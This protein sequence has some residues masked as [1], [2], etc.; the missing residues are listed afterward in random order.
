[1]ATRIVKKWAGVAKPAD[2]ARLFLTA[3]QWMLQLNS[4]ICPVP[5]TSSGLSKPSDYILGCRSQPRCLG[6][7][8][9]RRET[10]VA[11]F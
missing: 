7:T 8:E 9:E 3:R 2:P 11:K 5:K 6:S 10:I 1:M 4:P